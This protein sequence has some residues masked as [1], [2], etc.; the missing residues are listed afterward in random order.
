[1]RPR[2]YVRNLTLTSAKRIPRLWSGFRSGRAHGVAQGQ[3]AKGVMLPMCKSRCTSHLR[4]G[5]F[6]R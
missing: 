2:P 1:M 4:A 3:A 6:P 5:P